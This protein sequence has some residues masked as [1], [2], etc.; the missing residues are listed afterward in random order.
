MERA[1]S[2]RSRAV[3]SADCAGPATRLTMRDIRLSGLA[4]MVTDFPARRT[5]QILG[6]STEARRTAVG[7]GAAALTTGP[8][9]LQ[10][11]RSEAYSLDVFGRT[12]SLVLLGV[13]AVMIGAS[14]FVAFTSSTGFA[15]AT[16]PIELGLAIA[17]MRG[18]DR[19][20]P[21]HDVLDDLVPG[22]RF[23][24]PFRGRGDPSG[25]REPR[26]P[27]PVRGAGAATAELS[28]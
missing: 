7:A 14:L 16:A 18:T 20:D 17:I 8:G 1:W 13:L 6:A 21:G 12:E 4:R 9:P 22:P 10:Q 15:L 3:G 27:V 28:E 23:P 25:V 2:C 11:S 24:W 19:G 26:R 5:E